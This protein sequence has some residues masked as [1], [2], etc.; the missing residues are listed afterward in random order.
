MEIQDKLSML[1]FTDPFD[2]IFD[3]IYLRMLDRICLQPTSIQVIAREVTS[4]IPKYHSIDIHHRNDVNIESPN[5][6]IN[7]S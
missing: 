7:L 3:G 2:V 1:P 5:Q 4:I 6:K